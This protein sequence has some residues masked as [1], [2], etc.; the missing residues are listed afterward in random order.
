MKFRAASLAIALALTGTS[1]ANGGEPDVPN[2]HPSHFLQR[3]RPDGGWNP[4]GGLFH[5]WNPHCF[6]QACAP[7]DYCRKPAP[8]VCW[9]PY[10]PYYR[11]AD[12]HG[13]PASN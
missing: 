1:A 3:I 7:N 6:P 4:G 11:W 12:G 10:P 13:W 8:N 9:P 2:P 5:W